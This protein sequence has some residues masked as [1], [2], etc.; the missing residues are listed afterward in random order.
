MD[1]CCRCRLCIRVDG[2]G[3]G[4]GR[5]ISQAAGCG[6]R[7]SGQGDGLQRPAPSSPLPSPPPPLSPRLPFLLPTVL[8]ALSGLSAVRLLLLWTALLLSALPLRGA[9]AVHLWLRVRP[10]LVTNHVARCAAQMA[11][12]EL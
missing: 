7:A 1:R 8:P 10:V 3:L 5:G 4:K 11:Q 12:Q 2:A 6:T 9:G